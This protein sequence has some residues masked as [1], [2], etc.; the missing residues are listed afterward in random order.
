M[1]TSETS[2]TRMA[3]MATGTAATEETAVTLATGTGWTKPR[4]S[5]RAGS[6]GSVSTRVLQ[7][8]QSTG[9]WEHY[10]VLMGPC[11]DGSVLGLNTK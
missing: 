7:T 8:I 5:T 10:R 2:E 11:S 6:K 4:P 1:A 9:T 3:T